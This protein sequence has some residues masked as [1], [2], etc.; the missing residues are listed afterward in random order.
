VVFG[1]VRPDEDSK[2]EVKEEKGIPFNKKK[3]KKNI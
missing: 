3:Y 2:E 1:R